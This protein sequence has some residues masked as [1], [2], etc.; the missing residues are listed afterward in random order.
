MTMKICCNYPQST[1]QSDLLPLKLNIKLKTHSLT[2]LNVPLETFV[3]FKTSSS[4][5]DCDYRKTMAGSVDCISEIRQQPIDV[6]NKPLINTISSNQ[7]QP[8]ATTNKTEWRPILNHR[9]PMSTTSLNDSIARLRH[10][11]R[12]S[13]QSLVQRKPRLSLLRK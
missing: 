4:S 5:F 3:G 11:N 12:L 13:N 10:K 9:F 6:A 7:Q 2:S 1:E 8:P